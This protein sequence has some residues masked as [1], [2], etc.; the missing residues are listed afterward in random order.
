MARGSVRRHSGGV[1]FNYNGQTH[2]QTAVVSPVPFF[3]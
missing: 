3:F 2:G 1:L